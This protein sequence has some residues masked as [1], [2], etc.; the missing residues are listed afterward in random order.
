[1][2]GVPARA[3]PLASSLPC[4]MSLCLRG[5]S[6][7]CASV[8]PERLDFPGSSVV[9]SPLPDDRRIEAAEDQFAL[10][11]V[12]GAA[13]QRDVVHRRRPLVPEGL[14]VV[15]FQEPPRR[16]AAR[17]ADER[18]LPTVPL[19]D[20]ANHVG[21]DVTGAIFG[22]ARGPRSGRRGQLLL[23]DVL[24][25]QVERTLEDGRGIA[26][27]DLAAEQVLYPPQ[28]VVGFLRDR[29]LHA[30]TLGGERRDDRPRR[31]R[32]RG[33]WRWSGGRSR[34]SLLLL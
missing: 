27:R 13:A 1:M 5:F 9:L 6:G 34:G 28:L 16:A 22:C 32:P 20:C 24:Q 14:D 30:I 8:V 3:R 10:V 12:V 7:C 15:P 19:P 17:P 18:A 29:E 33:G 11:D 4:S 2:A 23:L 25:Q 31:L 26:A 21:R